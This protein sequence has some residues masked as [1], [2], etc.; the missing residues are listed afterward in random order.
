MKRRE[1]LENMMAGAALAASVPITCAPD[2]PPASPAPETTLY[3]VPNS[4]D[5]VSGWL[6]DFQVERNTSLNNYLDHLDRVRDDPNYKFA[7]SEVPNL[8]SLIQFAPERLDELRQRV[9]EGRVELCNACFLEATINLSG[10]ETLV[11]LVA[12]GLRWYQQVLNIRPRYAWMIDIV[13]AHQQL[14]QFVAGLGLEAVIFVRHNPAAKNA[15]WW[16]APDGTRALAICNSPTYSD[17]PEFFSTETPLTPAYLDGMAKQI[18]LKKQ[19]SASPNNTLSLAGAGDY[20]TAPR[21]K[22]YPTEFLAEWRRRY[23]SIDIRF[24]TPSDY[25]N[26]LRREMQSG[27]TRLEEYR[28]GTLYSWNA[29]WVDIPS[30]KRAHREHEQLLL[31]AEMLATTAS[32]KA[33]STYPSQ[34][35]ADGWILLL[36]NTDRNVLWGSAAG[37]PFLSKQAWNVEDRYE[38]LHAMSQDTVAKS[39]HAL[40]RRGDGLVAFNSLN[41]RRNDPVELRVP[42]GKRV[43]GRVCE[44]DPEFPGMLICQTDLGPLGLTSLELEAAEPD[45]LKEI[46]FPEVVENDH[47]IARFDPKSGVLTSLKVKPHG[48]ELLGGPAN[49]LVVEDATSKKAPDSGGDWLVPRPERKVMARSMDFLPDLRARRGPLST[50][51]SI[52]SDFY[53]GS[54]LEQHVRLY[55]QHPRIDFQVRLDLHVQDVLIV[56]DIPLLG[57]VLER[58][59]GIPYGFE[60]RD[61]RHP[62]VPPEY[63][64]TGEEKAIGYTESMLPAIRWSAYR[65]AGSGGL[66]ILD[67]GLPLREVHGS[68]VI[69][70]LVNAVTKY[71]GKYPN[72]LLGSQGRNVFSYALVPYA[73]SWQEAAIPKLAYEFNAP[74]LTQVDSA[75]KQELPFVTTTPNVIVEAMRRLHNQIELRLYEWQGKAG[76]AEVSLH[77]PHSAAMKT[78]LIGKETEKLSVA[79]RYKIQVRPQEIVT[80]RFTVDSAVAEPEPLRSWDRIV[81]AEKRQYLAKR[82]TKKGFV[83]DSQ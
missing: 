33:D 55:H 57:D 16:V 79:P 31:S 4:H 28:G 59:R 47:Y 38:S 19:D 75:V 78:N 45:L 2:D 5:V 58:T 42:A 35:L 36:M 24:S 10:G 76:E 11:Q 68:L 66:A 54:H 3:F 83:A 74:V 60:S 29:F 14:P 30:I 17:F 6:T 77:L 32:L 21:R 9:A 71:E 50:I 52:A 56:A 67:R 81:P 62:F 51:I 34:A 41:W 23:P 27:E 18:A 61:P 13:G 65:Q 44:S 12:Q 48:N 53:G 37:E 73:G 64:M 26:A 20:S 49:V 43:A 70:G 46:P 25:V 63:H 40:T 7:F 82:I 1:F 22:Q 80:L 39:L 69:L 8:I 15:F 72:E